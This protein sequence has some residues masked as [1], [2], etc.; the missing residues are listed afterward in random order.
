M[1]WTCSK[2]GRGKV[3]K[4]SYEMI[5]NRKKKIRKTQTHL[6]GRD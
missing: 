5:S 2:N 6:G 4:R 3:N 1:V